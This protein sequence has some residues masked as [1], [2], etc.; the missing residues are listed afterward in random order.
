MLKKEKSE[1]DSEK[2]KIIISPRLS[3]TIIILIAY[4]DVKNSIDKEIKNLYL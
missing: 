3:I 4:I 1:S 2:Y